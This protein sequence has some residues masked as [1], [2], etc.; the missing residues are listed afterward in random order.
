MNTLTASAAGLSTLVL[1]GLVLSSLAGQTI[2]PSSFQVSV[3][4]VVLSSVSTLLTPLSSALGLESTLA[5]SGN[6]VR[7]GPAPLLSW[8]AAGVVMGLLSRRAKTSIPPALITSSL[9]YLALIGLSIYV[10][11]R[12][13]GA[14]NWAHYLSWVSST[15]LL[16]GPLDFVLIFLTPAASSLATAGVKELITPRPAPPQ[17]RRRFWEWVEEE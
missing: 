15:I 3:L 7:L 1:A 10:L 5:P 9:V 17:P 4:A 12:L 6:V 16:E 2:P 13:P 8:V 14:V 11:P